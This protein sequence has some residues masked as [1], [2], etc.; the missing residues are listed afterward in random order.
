MAKRCELRWDLPGTGSEPSTVS[1]KDVEKLGLDDNEAAQINA[2]L[3]AEHKRFRDALR[4][5]YVEVTGDE[6]AADALSP[7]ALSSEI[8][9]K[10]PKV[11]R[12]VVYRRLSRERAGL[13]QPPAPGAQM[14]ALERLMR[15][16]TSTGDRGE[17]VVGAR[18]SPDLA[19]RLR[20][21]HGGWGSKSR[22]A[23]GC[24]R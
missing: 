4:A 3:A 17:K 13:Q 1:P 21:L 23:Y 8:D 18:V 11:E 5:L 9:D 16:L 12:K 7:W 2:A 6:Q 14:S 20:E 15:L 19:R 10:S 22:S 24:P